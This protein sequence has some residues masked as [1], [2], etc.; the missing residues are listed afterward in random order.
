M[1]CALVP[2]SDTTAPGIAGGAP[3]RDITYGVYGID[4]DSSTLVPAF[5]SA[6]LAYKIN[7]EEAK[8]NL[9]NDN[10]HAICSNTLSSGC[11]GKNTY[12]DALSEPNRG[13]RLSVDQ[14]FFVNDQQ[15]QV[16]WMRSFA[17]G[18]NYWFGAPTANGLA[19]SQPS[20]TANVTF[21][22]QKIYQLQPDDQLP[23]NCQV[24]EH[25]GCQKTVP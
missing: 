24:D 17:G 2:I 8:T 23:F 20:Q 5:S 18:K 3:E 13:S 10:N 25:G 6:V 15:V 14:K 1:I 16:F 22:S 4:T 9:N 7:V 21:S 12:L 11:S 19:Q